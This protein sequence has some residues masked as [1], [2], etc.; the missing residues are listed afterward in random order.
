QYRRLKRLG[1]CRQVENEE[2]EESC[3][4]EQ[5]PMVP[6]TFHHESLVR[7]MWTPTFAINATHFV[8]PRRPN[9]VKPDPLALPSASP[10]GSVLPR[11]SV[12][13]QIARPEF[14]IKLEIQLQC[15]LTNAR[16]G[17]LLNCAET[18]CTDL[19]EVRQRID[20]GN[21]VV[22]E[23]GAIENVE[24][25]GAEFESPAL[26]EYEAFGGVHVPGVGPRQYE[27][28]LTGIAEAA[29]RLR[30]GGERS[31][32]EPINTRLGIGTG[33]DAGSRASARSIRIFARE[34]CSPVL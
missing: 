4:S 20:T 18:A 12:D 17:R 25:L 31:L 21:A 22:H 5:Y 27:C 14:R 11:S 10:V 23:I 9:K 6:E 7:R 2:K 30:L 33:I 32:V 15:Q 8:R 13:L 26:G 28:I 19:L 1:G 34:Q 3:D 24:E 16:I 29:R